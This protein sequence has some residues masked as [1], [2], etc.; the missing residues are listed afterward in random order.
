MYWLIG[1]DFNNI[2]NFD[3]RVGVSVN[4][5]EIRDFK[6]CVGYC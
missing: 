3:E 1:G 4:V 2:L 6:E 5:N